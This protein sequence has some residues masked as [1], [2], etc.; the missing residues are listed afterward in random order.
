[1]KPVMAF[2]TKEEANK[3]LVRIISEQE[4]RT[5]LQ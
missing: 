1:M 5:T 3:M 2:D 4:L